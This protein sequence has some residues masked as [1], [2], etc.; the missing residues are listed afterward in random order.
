MMPETD[1][2]QEI[3]GIDGVMEKAQKAIQRAWTTKAEFLLASTLQRPTSNKYYGRLLQYTAELSSDLKSNWSPA[4]HP[5]LVALVQA[6]LA[7]VEKTK[8]LAAT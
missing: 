2:H 1:W 3:A 8:A 7:T 4:V 6:A 5:D